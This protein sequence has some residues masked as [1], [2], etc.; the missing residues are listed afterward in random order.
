MMSLRRVR[1]QPVTR[2]VG[3]SVGV[4]KVTFSTMTLP[5]ETVRA[6]ECPTMV[7]PPLPLSMSVTLT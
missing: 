1:L 4:V 7:V 5:P 6:G 2:M 3:A